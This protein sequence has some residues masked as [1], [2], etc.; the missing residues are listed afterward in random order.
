MQM[1]DEVPCSSFIS[2]M[3]A[4]LL[5]QPYKKCLLHFHQ[6]L[7]RELELCCLKINIIRSK[8]NQRS[9]YIRCD[10]ENNEHL[11]KSRNELTRWCLEQ[12][13]RFSF[14]TE[15]GSIALGMEMCCVESE[16]NFIKWEYLPFF[17]RVP[18]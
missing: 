15:T 10:L 9:C 4:I 16:Q 11:S 14:P 6:K 8:H 5:E 18:S 1:N 13:F 2:E 7:S 17:M 12:N 3:L